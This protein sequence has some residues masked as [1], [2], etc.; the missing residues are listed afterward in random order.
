M[1]KPTKLNPKTGAK[2][3]PDSRLAGQGSA[4]ENQLHTEVAT[5]SRENTKKCK[6]KWEEDPDFASGMLMMVC[7]PADDLGQETHVFCKK[8]GASDYIRIKSL[9]SMVDI[10]KSTEKI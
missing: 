5:P 9:G 1:I 7:G 6:H 4:S 2:V 8:C 3:L 10:Y